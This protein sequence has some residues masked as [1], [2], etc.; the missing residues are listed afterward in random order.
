MNTLEKTGAPTYGRLWV[1][2]CKNGL[3]E[4]W[5]LQNLFEYKNVFVLNWSTQS[6]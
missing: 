5:C 2:M 3:K 6:N 4:V 1:L